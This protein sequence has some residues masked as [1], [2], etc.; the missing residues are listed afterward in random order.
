MQKFAYFDTG[1]EFAEEIA[2]AAGF[3][4]YKILGNVYESTDPADSYV[5]NY[6]CPFSRSCLT[7]GMAHSGEWA[8]IA[9]CHGCDVTNNQ[10]DIWKY[11]VKTDFLY[12]IN[13]PANNNQAS[14]SFHVRELRRFIDHLEKKFGVNISTDKLKNAIRESNEIKSMLRK[15]AALR[16]TKDISNAE[17]NDIMRKS[18]QAPK[19]AL[20]KELGT[21]L[22]DWQN[23]PEFPND[24][25]PM[26][27]TGT[28]ITFAEAMDVFEV[29][30]IRIVRDDMSL[31][32]RYFA[33][34]IPETG[35]PVEALVEY[36][37]KIPQPPTRLPF[38]AR[39]G[40]LRK[41]LKETPVK[42]VVYQILKFCE[43]HTLDVPYYTEELKKSGYKVLT[44]EREYTPTI[45][46]QL[47][48]RLETF[49]DMI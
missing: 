13:T 11:H 35:D 46:Q 44:I 38:E 27:V 9:F 40:Y 24:K 39:L 23:R 4:P 45:D 2:M 14:R 6:I 17:Y 37:C 49:K 42:G 26:L 29:A 7:E 48:S 1:H 32:E 33:E 36:N 47:V 34:S 21:T 28:D 25:V 10:Y 16:S 43:P 5:H 19:D 12:W 8:G 41:C 30:G 18:V 20:I 3:T 15:L 31:G 22:E